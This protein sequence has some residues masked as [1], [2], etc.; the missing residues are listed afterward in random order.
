[1]LRVQLFGRPRL[2]LDDVA[3]PAGGRPKVVPLLGYLLVHRGSALARRTVANALWPDDA[4][5][6]ARANLR[7]HLNYLHALLPPAAEDRPWVLASS[8]DVRWNPACDAWLDVDEFE[9]LVAIP[10][11]LADAVALYG[12][13]LL[14]G[15]DEEWVEPERARLQTLY[16][17]ALETLVAR[18]RAARD[19]AP[20]IA[21]AQRLLADDP[22]REDVLRTLIRLRHEAG[23]R[24]GALQEYERF[25]RVLRDELGTE[26]M[27]ETRA[28]YASIADD[29]A[30][31]DDAPR[32]SSGAARDGGAK[33]AF[34]SLPFVG[35]EAELAALRERWE[36]AVAGYGGLVLVGGEAGI[37]KTRLVRELVAHCEARGAQAY[38]AG[39]TL[40][41]TVPY[42]AFATLLRVVA[43]LA[44]TVSVDPL[45]L[46]AIAALAPSIAEHARDLPPLPA[47]DPARERIRLFE[48]CSSVWEAI[49]TRRPVVLVV[50]DVQ[51][52]GAATLGMLEHLARGALRSRVLI[53]A[54]YREDELD[55]SHPLRAMRR[56]LER[57]ASVS[58]VAL[59][60]LARE[61]VEE[62][63]RALDGVDDSAALARVLHERSDGNPFFLEEML[64][65][66]GESGDLPGD[67][68]VP[69][70][71]RDVLAARLARLGERAQTLAE[72]AAVIGR[73]FDAEL[74][75]ETTGW[76]EAAV[77]DALGEL[78]D[79]RIVGEQPAGTGFDYA[80]NHHLIQAM[81]YERVAPAG[82]ARRHRR[83]AHV[84]TELYA[85]RR[86]DLAAELALH[87]DR[88]GEPE[89]AAERYLAAARRALDVYGNEDAARSLVRA[90]E[91]STS[92]R[93]RFDALLLR[94]RIAAADGARALQAEIIA[95]LTQLAR[96]IDDEDAACTALERRIALADVT[97]D[98]RR[99]RVLVALLRRR[100]R[101]SGAVRWHAAW[102]EAE[103][104]YRRAIND[105]GAARD[106][107]A[108]LI[109][110]TERTG[111]RGAH[112][113]ARLAFAD[114]YIYE[115]RLDEAYRALDELRDAVHAGGDQGAL[116]RTLIA[117]SRA[118]LAQ[119]D[120]AAM[121]RFATE[122]HEVSRA[123]G[124]REGEAL[125]LH[126]IAN[127]LV[128]T[129]RV[130]DAESYYLRALELYER[131]GHRVGLASI[132]VDLGLFYTELGLLDR[133]LELYARAREIAAEI[134][135]P[136]VA[137][138][139]RID[140]SYC[141]RLRGELA[142]AKTSAEEALALARDIKSQHLESAALGTLG[143]AECA[144]G[145]Y[146]AAI[147]HLL[148]AVE[149][150]RPAGATP[151]LGDN[152]CALAHALLRA[153]DAD[154]A[155]R[156]ADELL[157]LYDANPKLAP[158]P[159]EWLWTAAQVAL[160]SD[161]ADAAR[162]LLRQAHSVMHARAAVIDDAAAREAYLALPFNAAVADALSVPS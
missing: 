17:G 99:E 100:A 120:Y 131:I 77:L 147:A 109:A 151:R 64:R 53:V 16:R 149:L 103:A 32:G 118:A 57:D 88:G 125:A 160:A 114:T 8:G 115:G 42:Q 62:L 76:L 142:A 87:W 124:D 90:L 134:G 110:L 128:Y 44:A 12:G 141:L 123:I 36:S 27:A 11:R 112:A 37:G 40:P 116:V 138:V 95:D 143:A 49:A 132:F 78:T 135:F 24:A 97:G 157:A 61:H 46:S 89:L 23:D 81:V 72:V 161:R 28:A 129:F 9:R 133:A 117:F 34:T 130:G 146:A 45:W 80:F 52:A 38:A 83:V 74:L 51:W 20:A 139:E 60:R 30:P 107:F 101:R 13:E 14:A 55:L 25:A 65:D 156:A 98:R 136:F 145:D 93:V 15:V 153:G 43:P 137:C 154:A 1:M 19:Y 86:D 31:A 92:R 29:A 56:R 102:L 68:R 155:G 91:L 148:P 150:R 73:G 67:E 63:V 106:A 59:A 75:R 2:S 10:Q 3:L 119:Q 144:S 158:Q 162:K 152:L 121:S 6:E 140:T 33:A 26:P 4:E 35:R 18:L 22:W 21:A 41:E 104:R 71:L 39:T 105:F 111:D 54:T 85:D 70:A 50:E 79:R 48:A 94:E 5:D 66:L 47:V 122:A 7:R 113:N 127:G 84:M 108:E 159:T 96:T 82:R 69:R 58:H 126:T